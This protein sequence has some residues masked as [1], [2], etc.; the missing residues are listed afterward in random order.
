MSFE[1]SKPFQD[2][3]HFPRGLRRC[4]EFTVAEAQLLEQSGHAMLGLYTGQRAPNCDEE[5]RF[6]EQVQ[7]GAA[8]E[9][10]HAKVWL[11]YLKVIGPK[12]VHRLC[13]PMA[14]GSGDDDYEPVEDSAE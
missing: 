6:F 13:S 3:A 1:S 5:Q 14:S 10:R 4:G 7:Q 2:F 9:S 8:T 11:K 12:R